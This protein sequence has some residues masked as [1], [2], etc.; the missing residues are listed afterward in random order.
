MT[1]DEA[2]QI[3]QVT[4]PRLIDIYYRGI[5]R[6]KVSVQESLQRC[7]DFIKDAWPLF[8]ATNVEED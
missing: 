5:D 8:I 3:L 1:Y 4:I 6:K 2:E 7:P